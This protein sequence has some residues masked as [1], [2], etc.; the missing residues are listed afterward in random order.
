MA[1]R[2]KLSSNA[3]GMHEVF[4][5][6]LYANENIPLALVASLRSL[7]HDVVAMREVGHANRSFPDHRVLEEAVTDARAVLTFNRWDFVALDRRAQQTGRTHRGMVVCS[8]DRDFGGLAQR[9][10]ERIASMASLDGVLV[11]VDRDS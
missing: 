11:R 3:I 1:M 5:H 10:H 4:F 9:I 8:E 2:S 6:R 7:G